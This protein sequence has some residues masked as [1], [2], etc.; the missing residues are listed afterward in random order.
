MSLA[1]PPASD[2]HPDRLLNLHLNNSSLSNSPTTSTAS[3]AS[4]LPAVHA[5]PSLS[6][7]LS[8]VNP[9][10][11]SNQKPS[12]SYDLDVFNQCKTYLNDKNH[13]GLAL[14]S[15]QKGTPPFLRFKIWPILLKFHPFVL[16]PFI[17]PDN[18]IINDNIQKKKD[19]D[20]DSSQD[21][22]NGDEMKSKDDILRDQI[23]KDLKK[24]IQR[25]KFSSGISDDHYSNDLID[26]P[27]GKINKLELMIFEVIEKSVFKFINKWGK[28]IKYD[29]ALTWIA[30]GLAEWLPPLPH[31]SWVLVG[32]ESNNN[33]GQSNFNS[34]TPTNSNTNQNSNES[35][36]NNSFIQLSLPNQKNLLI[37]NVFDDY[38]NYIHNT[39]G[40]EEYLNDLINDDTINNMTFHDVFERLALVVLHSPEERTR[41]MAL[42]NNKYRNRR[43]SN[44]R[45]RNQRNSSTRISKS[46]NSHH[47]LESIRKSLKNLDAV[48]DNESVTLSSTNNS[49]SA[50]DEEIG[51]F[52]IDKTTLPISGGTI[53]ERVSFFIYILRKLLPELSN[54]FQEEQILNKFG[55]SDDEWLI[56]W[57][58]YGGSKVWSPLDRGRIWDSILG[59]RI[60]NKK[61]ERKNKHYYLDKLNIDPRTLE[62]LGPDSFWS[63]DNDD[64][65][66]NSEAKFDEGD[67]T[68]NL[69]PFSQID[70]HI[71][72]IF[73]SLALL[74]SKENTLIELDQHEIRQY[75]SKLPTKSYS[76]SDKYKQYKEQK[77]KQKEEEQ[78]NRQRSLSASSTSTTSNF[79]IGSTPPS[80]SIS[81]TSDD[82]NSDANDDNK[83]ITNNSD[84][85][86]KVNFMDNIIN[87]AGELWR[88]WLWLEMVDD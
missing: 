22:A 47:D 40:L 5:L 55:S 64:Y 41:K 42:A 43:D 65:D 53:E 26:T 79:E 87:E 52:K 2:G 48:D 88:K 11:H 9:K 35:S 77:E 84:D 66:S 78:K 56:W 72:L 7:P 13:H 8:I 34:T 80:S 28:I 74:K 36:S 50:I 86:F 81:T 69:I 1:S 51:G 75:L 60:P 62:K 49:S 85:T 33:P 25:I 57:L 20:D 58:K 71:E 27:F 44:N 63:V 23:R 12:F 46:S 67:N 17:Q 6:T 45:R 32:R 39:K 21:S 82:S 15:R 70:P 31:T 18:E 4:T 37:K 24:Y 59:W 61:N 29:Q 14:I 30:L 19:S 10:V 73:I 3:N 38:S 83:I 68:D 54:F 16:N 76:R